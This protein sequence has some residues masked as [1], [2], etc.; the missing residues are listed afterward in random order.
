MII[1]ICDLTPDTIQESLQMTMD[2]GMDFIPIFKEV[3][4]ANQ[5]RKI[6]RALKELDSQIHSIKIKLEANDDSTIFKEEIFPIIIKKIMDEPQ[7]DKIKIIIDGFEQTID[8]NISKEDVVF[9]FY[10]VLEEL[11]I[12]DIVFLCDNYLEKKEGSFNGKPFD[13]SF[14]TEEEHVDKSVER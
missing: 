1:K 2:I 8:K 10:D 6:N 5:H 12:A 13:D 7:E 11:R 3:Y 9:H 4:H 14:T